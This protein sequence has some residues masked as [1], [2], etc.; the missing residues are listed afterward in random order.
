[1]P[2]S[3]KEIPSPDGT[4]VRS[5]GLLSTA[6]RWL[7]S[8]ITEPPSA[9]SSLRSRRARP[10]PD[11]RPSKPAVQL[12]GAHRVAEG[13][14]LVRGAAD[15]GDHGVGGEVRVDGVQVLQSGQPTR[16]GLQDPDRGLREPLRTPGTGLLQRLLPARERLVHLRSALGEPRQE[17]AGLGEA[18]L[19]VLQLEQDPG[20]L[21]VARV[22]GVRRGEGPGDGL[23]EQGELRG[24]LG[25]SLP[26]HQFPAPGVECRPGAV[27]APQDLGDPLQD[28]RADGGVAHVQPGDDLGDRPEAVRDLREPVPGRR[29]LGDGLR[30]MRP[31]R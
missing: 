11:G 15:L 9:Y 14:E 30:L 27:G 20:Q 31:P 18:R 26:G 25:L 28:R 10:P 21:F 3:A 19:Q 8:R 4:R 16:D 23:A 13:A 6:N 12:V 24:E 29:G 7:P 17:V 2:V 22:G 5:N 1:M